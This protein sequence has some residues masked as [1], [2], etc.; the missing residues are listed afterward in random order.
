MDLLSLDNLL[1]PDVLGTT[2]ITEEDISFIVDELHPVFG[3]ISIPSSADWSQ[4]HPLARD[5]LVVDDEL[6]RRLFTLAVEV[7]ISKCIP[8][9]LKVLNRLKSS[10]IEEFLGARGEIKAGAWAASA[11]S[12]VEFITPNSKRGKSVDLRAQTKNGPVLIEVK[13]ENQ[14]DFPIG[15]NMFQG[16]FRSG[17]IELNVA[18]G[19]KLR[20]N[21]GAHWID[22]IGATCRINEKSSH[23]SWA[24]HSVV[25]ALAHD[26][27]RRVY[28]K[29]TVLVK[30]QTLKV[31]P[32][33]ECTLSDVMP[34]S[35]ESVEVVMPRSLSMA[36][37][38]RI[39]R[40]LTN[41]EYVKQAGDQD[42]I[43]FFSTQQKV[44]S[45][46]ARLTL[47][48]LF[49]QLTD[50]KAH[51]LGVVIANEKDSDQISILNWARTHNETDTRKSLSMFNS[52]FN[53]PPLLRDI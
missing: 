51:C 18:P 12:S 47:G 24:F 36:T 27:V 3:E 13:S 46:A 40:D 30:H 32:D 39:I 26:A 42:F 48:N 6:L 37:L 9:A 2:R 1:K 5:L 20:V 31:E 14:L 49:L 16:W 50:L 52:V 38:G 7:K 35:K 34:A 8:N 22:A 15:M 45:E 23:S 17:L 28:D 43:F 10:K 44:E 41:P 4:S 25:N 29:R 21:V 19:H 53:K 33:L 11:G